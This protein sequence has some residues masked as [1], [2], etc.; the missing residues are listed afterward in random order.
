M[1]VMHFTSF[2]N[3]KSFKMHFYPIIARHVSAGEKESA[4]AFS[5]VGSEHAGVRLR[6]DLAPGEPQPLDGA[7]GSGR[8]G[9]NRAVKPNGRGL[10]RPLGEE[11]PTAG[12]RRRR[13][14]PELRRR[15]GSRGSYGLEDEAK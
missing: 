9:S 15:W 10:T 5:T 12:R 13:R 14:W 3:H 1:K 7:G 4:A 6:L 8:R 11:R 2:I